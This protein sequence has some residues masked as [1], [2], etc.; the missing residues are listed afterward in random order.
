MLAYAALV[1]VFLL[2]G[3][4][5]AGP[6]RMQRMTVAKMRAEDLESSASGYVYNQQQGLPVYYLHYTDH[7]SGSYYR[8]PHTVHYTDAPVARSPILQPYAAMDKRSRQE[9][10]AYSGRELP[11]HA[12]V[13]AESQPRAPYYAENVA[14]RNEDDKTRDAEANDDETDK[15]GDKDD[16]DIRED[17]SD[18]DSQGDIGHSAESHVSDGDGDGRNEFYGSHS[19]E[20]GESEGSRDGDS[21]SA[22]GNGGKY[23][24][25]E[26]SKHGETGDRGYKNHR[27]FSKGERGR[28]DEERHEGKFLCL[29]KRS[30]C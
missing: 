15:T 29:L 10:V 19:G 6:A 22:A 18:E 24:S 4:I 11:K 16:G 12:A 14:K 21:S 28:N 20:S 27:E 17:E 30:Y 23:E 7:G 26:F 13:S 9:I 5:E 1:C 2:T 25:H 8:A 3:R